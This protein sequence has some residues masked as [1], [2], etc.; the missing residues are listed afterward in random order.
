MPLYN[1]EAFVHD[2]GSE[3]L[4]GVITALIARGVQFQPCRRLSTS[5]P[6]SCSVPNFFHHGARRH[7]V[8]KLLFVL[9]LL[10]SFRLKIQIQFDGYKGHQA[11]VHNLHAS[12]PLP[13]PL[14]KTARQKKELLFSRIL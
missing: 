6:I 5:S 1:R 12:L 10:G 8:H 3:C 11:A 9:Q 7:N 14:H 4:W 2:R 13:N